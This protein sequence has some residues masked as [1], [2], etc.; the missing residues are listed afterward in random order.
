MGMEE[1]KLK[2]IAELREFLEERAKT[3][4]AEL[5]GLR[6]ALDFINDLLLEKSFKRVEEIAKPATPPQPVSKEAAKAIPLKTGSGVLLAN[7]FVE[8]NSMRIVPSAEEKFDVNTP[9]FTAFFVEKI[10]NKMREADQDAVKRG[11]LSSNAAFNFN[12]ERDGDTIREITIRNVNPQR[13]REIRSAV[14][15][16]LE[17]M[18]EKMKS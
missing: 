17:K 14:R 3:L 11:E 6:T 10:L 13:E 2:K 15:W 12:I 4:E 5:E 1:E 8:E 9:P 7:L 16:T 18:Y